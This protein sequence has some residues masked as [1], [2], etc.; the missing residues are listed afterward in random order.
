MPHQQEQEQ[1]KNRSKQLCC[2][3][4]EQVL[5]TIKE[6]R[7]APAGRMPQGCRH[8]ALAAMQIMQSREPQ[9]RHEHQE[10]PEIA[11]CAQGSSRNEATLRT[12]LQSRKSAGRMVGAAWRKGIFGFDS[13]Q[14]ILTIGPFRN[15][16]GF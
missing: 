3:L 6:H 4:S 1:Q 5:E 7:M 15:P 13:V 11:P 8:I 12:A 14:L 16:N 10:H 9:E 2:Q